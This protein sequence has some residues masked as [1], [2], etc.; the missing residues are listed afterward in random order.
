[1]AT[2]PLPPYRMGAVKFDLRRQDLMAPEASG[3]VGG[4][5]MGWPL[6]AAEYESEAVSDHE[7]HL[8]GAWVRRQRGAINRFIATD[9]TRWYPR[10]YMPDGEFEGGFPYGWNGDAT[11]FSL[12]G[13][14]TEVTLTLPHGIVISPSDLLG[15]RWASGTKLAL[16][17]CMTGGTSYGTLKVEVEPAVHL[18]VPTGE[19]PAIA[20]FAKPGCLMRLTPETE[21]P[22]I[23]VG[24]VATGRIVGLQEIVP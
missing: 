15:F 23:S 10:A 13:D 6:W 21:V 1:M 3:K 22:A 24:G 12:N 19:T 11:S 2:Y 4:V 17:E 20:Y 16:V 8:W 9:P 18:V 14:R 7:A 5:Q